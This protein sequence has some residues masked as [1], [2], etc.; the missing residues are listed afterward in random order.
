MPNRP[1]G[2]HLQQRSAA[3]PPAP[4][5][6]WRRTIGCILLAVAWLSSSASAE[7]RLSFEL[8]FERLQLSAA[9]IAQAKRGEIVRGSV[10]PSH[11]RE[12]VSTLAFLVPDVTPSELV[13][14]ARQ[15]L[16]DQVDANALD[17]ALIE[18]TPVAG[19]FAEV[20]LQ[21]DQAARARAYT[22]ARPGSELNL[23]SDEIAAFRK[24]GAGAAATDVE[25]AVRSALFARLEAYRAR[26]LD[27][28]APYARSGGAQ[29]SVADD[30]RSA[31]RTLKTLDETVPAA[32]R[33]MLDYPRSVPPGTEQL[34]R[35]SQIDAQGTPTLLLTHNLY[36]PEGEAWV[37]MQRIFYVSTGF[38]CAQAAAVFLPVTRGTAVFYVNRTS[39]DQVAGFGGG[40]KRSLGSRVLGS[41]LEALFEKARNKA[42]AR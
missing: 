27:G 24:L 2:R 35:W 18:G 28:I 23:S 30:L 39:T 42:G 13:K 33:A 9:Q 17:F 19:D 1:V 26:G 29:R 20:M 15:G 8:F 10:K 32:Y 31:T 3:G 7:S 34:F 21:P 22:N 6:P 4:R 40:A 36:L 38:N 16:L 37:T 25:T 41:Q 11:E 12:L 5:R 14:E